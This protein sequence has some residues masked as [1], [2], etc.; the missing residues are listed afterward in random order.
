MY[1]SD[2]ISEVYT[3]SINLI[4]CLR[5]DSRNRL[6]G[7][8]RT[9]FA[10]S[11]QRTYTNVLENNRTIKYNRQRLNGIIIRFSL[12]S[13]LI[14]MKEISDVVTSAGMAFTTKSLVGRLDS[15][16]YFNACSAVFFELFYRLA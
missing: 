9:L 2:A 8:M 12:L 15:N 11:D 4:A 13:A 3:I 6:N 16:M 14:N 5:S 1:T 10:N 7:C